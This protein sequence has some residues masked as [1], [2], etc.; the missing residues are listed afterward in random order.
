MRSI[1]PARRLL[2][3]LT[4]V[5][6][7]SALVG[8]AASESGGRDEKRTRKRDGLAGAVRVDGSDATRGIVNRSAERF[9]RRHSDVR[10]TVGASGD[11]NA[12]ALFCAGEI[13]M[14]AVSR[15]FD[16][17]ERRECRT[18]GTRRRQLEVAALP[19]AVVVSQSNT[20]VDSLSTDQL[21]MLWRR[22]EPAA[23]W[24]ELDPLLPSA[25]IDPVG[26]KPDSPPATLIA[27]ALFGPVA[28]LMRDDYDVRDDAKQVSRAVAASPNAIGFLP[29]TEVKPEFGVRTVRVIP[30]QMYLEIRRDSLRRPEVRSFLRE[31]LA[32]PPEIRRADGA[33]PVPVSHRVYRKF[34]RP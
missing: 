28:P 19:I 4:P 10:V 11:E 3:Q 20:F 32:R 17:A 12:I 34:T 30:R 22:T 6:V 33:L 15:R 29:L 21:R 23:T 13:D 24:A 5:I 18:S 26:W 27:E 31:Y 14:A 2:L 16:R 7:V 25:P 1:S 9:E 8:I